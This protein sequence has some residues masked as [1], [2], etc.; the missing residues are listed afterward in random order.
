MLEKK[1]LAYLCYIVIASGIDIFNHKIT[2]QSECKTTIQLLKSFSAS[3]YE[4]IA[5]SRH[6]SQTGQINLLLT[7]KAILMNAT[8]QVANIIPTFQIAKKI[9][10]DSQFNNINNNEDITLSTTSLHELF[11]EFNE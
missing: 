4:C 5:I 1:D 3:D 2:N 6:K 11:E 10:Q 9:L 8:M 7:K